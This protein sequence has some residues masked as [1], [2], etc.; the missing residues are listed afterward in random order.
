MVE[1]DP[2]GDRIA[3]LEKELAEMRLWRQGQEQA[4]GLVLQQQLFAQ[5]A[6]RKNEMRI[7]KEKL[8]KSPANA[9]MMMNIMET[10]YL[11]SDAVGAWAKMFAGDPLAV[12]MQ[13]FVS[14]LTAGNIPEA[15]SSLLLC[16][17]FL[18]EASLKLD[19][20]RMLVEAASNSAFG[21]AA[22]VHMEDGHGFFAKDDEENTK[23][24]R[25]CEG[26]VRRDKNSFKL[27]SFSRKK[28]SRFSRGSGEEGI[29]RT[30][31]AA[32]YRTR[33]QWS[34]GGSAGYGQAAGY[35]RSYGGGYGGSYG[36]GQQ[37]Q[38]PQQQHNSSSI[39]LLEVEQRWLELAF[40][41]A[42]PIIR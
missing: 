24:L 1:G 15:S 5:Q 41:V 30:A 23:R 39:V 37:Q 13:D 38:Q 17:A 21:W 16:L 31:S 22:A 9:R 2:H 19:K 33:G 14:P 7:M 12:N 4:A 25:T 11:V 26:Y 32:G 28:F 42:Q 3:L 8:S 40:V 35:G 20:Q 6:L 36:G 34:Y 27:N 18:K 29:R 10:Q